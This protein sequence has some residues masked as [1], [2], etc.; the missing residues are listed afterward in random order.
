MIL[1]LCLLS[2][3]LIGVVIYAFFGMKEKDNSLTEMKTPL[4]EKERPF[5][6][7]FCG[8]GFILIFIISIFV[9]FR[10]SYFVYLRISLDYI[11]PVPD[12]PLTIT[13][14]LESFLKTLITPKWSIIMS[15]SFISLIAGI[16]ILL[17]RNWGRWFAIFSSCLWIA[18]IISI[19]IISYLTHIQYHYSQVFNLWIPLFSIFSIIFL[20]HSKV[21]KQFSP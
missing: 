12:M 2:V 9:C 4:V 1:F 14:F 3:I 11:G 21:K 5:G 7:I 19:W 16:G 6:V 13:F 17:L 10:E 18:L 20:T 15:A 8:I